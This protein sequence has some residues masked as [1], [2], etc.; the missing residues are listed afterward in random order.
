MV[1]T[2]LLI[3]FIQDCSYDCLFIILVS[4]VLRFIHFTCSSPSYICA[5]WV[6]LIYIFHI[7]TNF[8][9]S[10][11]MSGRLKHKPMS[12]SRSKRSTPSTNKGING[13]PSANQQQPCA[14]KRTQLKTDSGERLKEEDPPSRLLVS[15][16]ISCWVLFFVYFNYLHN[17]SILW[18]HFVEGRPM[19][20]LNSKGTGKCIHTANPNSYR[21]SGSWDVSRRCWYCND[22]K[23]ILTWENFN[24][25][26]KCEEPNA[27]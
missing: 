23:P 11:R 22:P 5:Y 7:N 17:L 12:S 18:F 25:T 10:S 3:F 24:Q 15:M 20:L 2:R 13:L 9:V 19:H 21:C 8:H 4:M 6:C 14:K 26:S 1:P 27:K 16:K